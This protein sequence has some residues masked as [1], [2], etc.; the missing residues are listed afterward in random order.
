MRQRG[1][2]VLRLRKKKRKKMYLEEDLK[3]TTIIR[4]LRRE[5]PGIL[6][7]V[8]DIY[9]LRKAFKREEMANNMRMA[10][11]TTITNHE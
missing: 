3:P 2:K 8:Q 5:Y 6:V 7:L 9:N 1:R 4:L 11:N 10:N